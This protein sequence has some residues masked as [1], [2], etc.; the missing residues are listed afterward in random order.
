MEEEE[1][2]EEEEEEE[3]EEEDTAILSNFLTFIS[4]SSS[5]VSTIHTTF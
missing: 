5:R 2:A 1:E 3:E 4:G